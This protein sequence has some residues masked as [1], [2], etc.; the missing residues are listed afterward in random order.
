MFDIFTDASLYGAQVAI[1]SAFFESP[2]FNGRPR[3]AHTYGLV[4]EAEL[5]EIL[6]VLKQLQQSSPT[7]ITK[8]RRITDSYTA[9]HEL[10]KACTHNST[11][12]NIIKL[13]QTLQ[14]QGTIVRLAGTPGNTAGAD[15]NKQAHD[16]AREC[17]L[18]SPPLIS[19]PPPAPTP[20]TLYMQL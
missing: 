11:E 2:A 18:T 8:F 5:L 17:L 16:A 10:N 4:K 14:Q 3:T 9:L 15:G 12:N 20:V 13:M 19:N 7:N 6:W 1:A